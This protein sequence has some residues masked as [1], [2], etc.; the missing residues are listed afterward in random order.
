M[1]FEAKVK[2]YFAAAGVF[3]IETGLRFNARITQ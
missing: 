2:Q 3:V 1:L